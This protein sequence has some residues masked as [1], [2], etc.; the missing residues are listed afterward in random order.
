MVS[1]K[2]AKCIQIVN[3]IISRPITNLN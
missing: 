1:Y 2:G 3:I